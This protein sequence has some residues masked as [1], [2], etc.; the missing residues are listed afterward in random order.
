M[1]TAATEYGVVKVVSTEVAYYYRSHA[2]GRRPTVQQGR[3]EWSLNAA[4][5][6]AMPAPSWECERSVCQAC[7]RG[8]DSAAFV[9]I[10]RCAQALIVAE[11]AS[12]DG[13]AQQFKDDR[14]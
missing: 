11:P 9:E 10:G 7:A 12:A 3:G 13:I 14:G 5:E 6:G 1:S 2:A 8:E 4:G